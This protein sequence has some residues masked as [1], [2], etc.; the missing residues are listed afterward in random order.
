MA[1]LDAMGLLSTHQTFT[2]E[3]ILGTSL[4]GRLLSRE[5]PAHDAS[6]SAEPV[7]V[8][9]MVKGTAWPTG[10]HEFE[11]EDEDPLGGFVI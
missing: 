4:E 5:A 7:R 1:V 2:H 11:V 3:G 8:I 9:P 10:R 6:G